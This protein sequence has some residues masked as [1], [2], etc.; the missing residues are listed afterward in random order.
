MKFDFLQVK[1]N[2]ENHKITKIQ[3]KNSKKLLNNSK[4]KKKRKKADQVQI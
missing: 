4:L 2:I 1:V 3:P